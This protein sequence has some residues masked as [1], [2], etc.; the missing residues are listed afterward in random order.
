AA[1]ARRARLTEQRRVAK[2]KAQKIAIQK[3]KT[4]EA[5]R[6]K[7]LKQKRAQ[8]IKAQEQELQ[9]KL[10]QQQ[11]SAE[12]SQLAKAKALQVRGEIDRYKAGIL[13]AIGQKWVVPGGANKELSSVYQIHLGPGGVVIDV[14]LLRSSGNAALDRSAKVAIFKASPL[15]VP[16]DPALFDN[17][18]EL[19]L[20][21]SPKTVVKENNETL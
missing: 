12:K 6:L 21:V 13:R 9:K 11:L 18:R 20:T 17:F 19:R 15:P 8:A 4:A 3:Q 5:A 1:A 10:M 16:K 7:V 14:E 2:L